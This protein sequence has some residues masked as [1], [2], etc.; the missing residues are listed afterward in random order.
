MEPAFTY[1]PKFVN[2]CARF[3]FELIGGNLTAQSTG[4]PCW[5]ATGELE[6]E[7]RF[8]R[9]GWK[10]SFLVLPFSRA[11]A[12]APRR[13]CSQASW[14]IKQI[15]PPTVRKKQT[16]VVLLILGPSWERIHHYNQ[17][18][19]GNL[20]QNVAGFALIVVLS[21]KCWGSKHQLLNTVKPVLS[22]HP[23]ELASD[24]L[25]EVF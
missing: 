19:R 13:A 8:Q 22:G 2:I 5:G 16:K 1:F 24:C 3:H 20:K 7:F 18:P 10:L 12:R 25:I 23:R 17:T 21:T 11:A 15:L 4:N 14:G 6:A 9:R